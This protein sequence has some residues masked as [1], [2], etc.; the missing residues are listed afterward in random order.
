MK[1][2]LKIEAI[3]NAIL[4]S[5]I[6]FFKKIVSSITPTSIKKSVEKTKVF[7]KNFKNN[8]KS[9]VKDKFTSSKNLATQNIQKAKLK[10]EKTKVEAAKKVVEAKSYNYKS[11]TPKKVGVI[12]AGVFAPLFSTV[13]KKL[14]SMAPANLAFTSALFMVFSLT[15]I[16]VIK[17][18]S[19]I[20]EKTKETVREPSSY[21]D[22]VDKNSVARGPFRN[23]DKMIISLADVDI[24]IYD[25]ERKGMQMLQVDFSFKASNRYIAK[26]FE[27]IQNEYVI[28]D[29]LNKSLLQVI[30]SFPMK[31]EG[32][33]ILRAK[34]KS[35]LNGLIKDL[36]IDGEIEDVYIHS[37]LNS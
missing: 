30:P 24:P 4:L 13:V 34:I 14:S 16:S 11:L 32:K 36:G 3:L 2:W 37:I 21:E 17:Q 1:I 33:N 22:E 19:E 18:V 28:R 9:F 15:S 10:V 27:K 7:S 6:N 8:S 26:Y 23:Y 31:P 35:E 29:R 12:I 20:E 5:I 25:E